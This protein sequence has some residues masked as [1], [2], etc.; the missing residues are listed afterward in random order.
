MQKIANFIVKR[1]TFIFISIIFITIFCAILIPKV[2]I[3]YDMSKYLPIDSDVS[4]GL[5][6]MN[7]KFDLIDDAQVMVKDFNE[8]EITNIYNILSNIEGVKSVTFDIESDKYFKDGN[9]L[10]L[11]TLT[12]KDDNYNNKILSDIKD[13]L[14]NYDFYLSGSS[15]NN[16]AMTDTMKN[17]MPLFLVVAVILIAIILLLI[18]SSWIEPI[19]FLSISLIA[20]II[21]YGTN[22]MFGEVSFVTFAIAALLQLALSMDYSI[23]L[24]DQYHHEVKDTEKNEAMKKAWVKSFNAILASSL[25]TIFGLLAM[26]FMSFSIGQDLGI[27]LAKGIVINVIVV[28]LAFPTFILIFDNILNKTRKKS[29]K[30]PTKFL[31]NIATKGKYS[32]TIVTILLIIGSF[33][34]QNNLNFAYSVGAKD[35]NSNEVEKVFGNTTQFVILYKENDVNKIYEVINFVAEDDVVNYVTDYHNSVGTVVTVIDFTYIANISPELTNNIFYLYNMK[36]N[37]SLDRI[38]LI[39]LIDFIATDIINNPD[40]AMLVD[41]S[42]K[43]QILETQSLLNENAKTLTSGD[44]KRMIIQ[45]NADIESD[46]ANN[47]YREL[48]VETEEILSESY[49]LGDTAL[50]NDIKDSFADET[51]LI[52]IITIIS[53]LIV[54]AV[55]YR[56][57]GLPIILV[58]LIQGAIW[59]SLCYSVFTS[60]KLFFLAYIIAQCIQMGAT[61]DYAILL[62]SNYNINRKKQDKK[63]AIGNAIKASIMTIF[64]SA[65]ILIV[66]A[67]TIALISSQEMISTVCLVI[68]RGTIVSAI[69]VLVSLPACLVLCDS[70]LEKTTFKTK[71]FKKNKKK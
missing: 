31:S 2:N 36:N 35:S 32:I 34:I 29:I 61:I 42:T 49:I 50:A 9:A 39:D 60:S 28:F 22:I 25:T 48:K 12:S 21:N 41:E 57:I 10:F 54:I 63:E 15:V 46:K 59:I 65:T 5:E 17:E 71:F 7:D 18:A 26:I 67:F 52:T 23:M 51:L 47:F 4:K 1:K 43:V 24:L 8:I 45:I 62:S 40:Y 44:Y 37:T 70:F 53:M 3:N 20:I 55:I 64:T 30:V 13:N 38:P 16:Q 68:G 14:D 56:S 69:V 11:L 33:F 6:I 27:V 66:A 19:L 58:T